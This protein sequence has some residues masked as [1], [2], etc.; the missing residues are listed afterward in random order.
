MTTIRYELD[1]ITKY[2]SDTHMLQDVITVSPDTS[3]EQSIVDES[4]RIKTAF[5]NELISMT[6][7]LQLERYIRYHQQGLSLIHI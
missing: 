4:T 2:V 7:E 6:S 5:M 1:K 3:I